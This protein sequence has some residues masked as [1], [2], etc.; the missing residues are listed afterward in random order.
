MEYPWGSIK[1]EEDNLS[2]AIRLYEQDEENNCE[3]TRDLLMEMILDA[4]IKVQPREDGLSELV[5]DW[6]H[7]VYNHDVVIAEGKKPVDGHNGFY[8]FTL[9]TEDMRA[10]PV[11]L[12]DGTA[13]YRNSLK[14]AV[15]DEGDLIATYTP[16]TMGQYGY[17]LFTDM[18]KPVPGRD[19][20]PIHGHGVASN[21]KH[22]EYRAQYAGHIT[23]EENT[24]NIEKLLRINGDLGLEVGNIHFIGDVEVCGDVRPGMTIETNGCI[25]VHGH[26]SSC[27]LIAGKNIVIDKGIQGKEDCLI[28]AGGNVACRFVESCRIE[29]EGTVYAKSVINSTVFAR[30]QILVNSGE[31]VVLS[32]YL[33]GL[34]GI[35]V[36]EA[37][38]D[39]G[40]TVLQ[41]GIPREELARAHSLEQE[42]KEME[43]KLQTFDLHYT[44]LSRMKTRTEKTEDMMRQLLKAKIILGSQLKK[45]HE[46]LDPLQEIAELAKDHN[47]IRI[48]GIAHDGIRIRID[49]NSL[50]VPESVRGVI[51]TSISGQILAFP[52][53]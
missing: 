41:S 22:T 35:Q 42:V 14:L 21:E 29:S 31:G 9:P 53:E 33:R 50:Q 51:Y 10:K 34:L 12:A 27:T 30:N 32:S 8:T 1:I 25:F 38:N 2:A 19:L 48:S 15:V 52:M 37:G 5:D 36:K 44:V 24:V 11:I 20:P 18:L 46:E 49:G 47:S 43:F 26:V 17:D 23:K 4:G 39:I 7:S 45:L 6:C 28:K 16:A 3:I 13:D 40:T